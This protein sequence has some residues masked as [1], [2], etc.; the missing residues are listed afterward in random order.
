MLGK[1]HTKKIPIRNFE[2]EKTSPHE[3]PA[4]EL[5]S[6]GRRNHFR[7]EDG[8]L[9]LVIKVDPLDEVDAPAIRRV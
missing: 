9:P 8:L 1:R 6:H 3:G 7:Q 5:P 2:E 4:L